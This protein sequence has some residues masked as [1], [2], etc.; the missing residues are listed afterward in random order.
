MAALN[1]ARRRAWNSE[2]GQELIEFALVFPMLLLVVLGIIDFGLLFRNYEVLTNAAR[3]GA[4]VAVLPGYS[5]TDVQNR[6]AQYVTAGGLTGTATTNVGATQNVNVG[7]SCIAVRPVT[8]TYP[9]TYLFL[10]PVMA[11]MGGGTFNNKTLTATSSMRSE[12]A[13]TACP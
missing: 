7:G 10:G 3:E 5:D 11:L 9:H 13:A 6:V 1:D 2:A 12:I 8:V 4:R